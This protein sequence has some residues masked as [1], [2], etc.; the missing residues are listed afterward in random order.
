MSLFKP[1]QFDDI[2]RRAEKIDLEHTVLTEEE[3]STGLFSS[4]GKKRSNLTSDT[5]YIHP[6]KSA[7]ITEDTVPTYSMRNKKSVETK[8]VVAVEIDEMDEE[9]L[10]AHSLAMNEI[11]CLEIDQNE[12]EKEEDYDM[13]ELLQM[14]RYAF[15][16]THDLPKPSP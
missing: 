3:K 8:P 7:K 10:L 15:G 1:I 4:R 6:T 2:V 5:E 14:N 9:A 16:S 11:E 12:D 13:D